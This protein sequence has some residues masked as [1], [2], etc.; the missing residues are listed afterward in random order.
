[1]YSQKAQLPLVILVSLLSFGCMSHSSKENE[2]T[3]IDSCSFSDSPFRSDDYALLGLDVA[4]L[5][6][7]PPTE[8]YN[9]L[10]FRGIDIF[11]ANSYVEVSTSPHHDARLYVGFEQIGD[12]MDYGIELELYGYGSKEDGF[13]QVTVSTSHKSGI[14]RI[15]LGCVIRTELNTARS[16]IGSMVYYADVRRELAE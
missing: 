13:P 3:I 15:D 7:M 2:P 16:Y 10:M 4:D 8:E 6:R 11:N 9:P 1:M 14:S 12:G 5:V